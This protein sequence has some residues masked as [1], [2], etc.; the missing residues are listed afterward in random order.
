MLITTFRA[1]ASRSRSLVDDL[2]SGLLDSSSSKLL[3][4]FGSLPSAAQE[5]TPRIRPTTVG[6]YAPAQVKGQEG[7]LRPPYIYPDH[8][9]M[10]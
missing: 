7:L 9:S 8:P 3:P 6:T 2:T 5:N 4:S 1:F 10:S